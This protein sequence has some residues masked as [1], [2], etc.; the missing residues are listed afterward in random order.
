MHRSLVAIALL[1]SLMPTIANAGYWEE[2]AIL[3]RYVTQLEALNKNLLMDAKRAVEPTAR[4]Q[5][6]YEQVLKEQN[7]IIAKLK[8]H[9]NTPL[10]DVEE[11]ITGDVYEQD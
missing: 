7:Q 10:R 6:N 11:A 4:I 1:I 3:E 2:R 9:L 8:N 5:L